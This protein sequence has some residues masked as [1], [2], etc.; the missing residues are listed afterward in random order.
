M[1][2]DLTAAACA[3]GEIVANDEAETRNV[4]AM[5]LCTR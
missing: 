2:A 5:S 4:S 3:G 1:L